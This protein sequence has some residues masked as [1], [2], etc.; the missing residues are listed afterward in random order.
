MWSLHG[1][2]EQKLVIWVTW[3]R[4]PPHPYIVKTLQKSSSPEPKGE[5]PW[6]LVCSTGALGPSKFVQIMTL[7]WL[8]PF[9]WQGQIL[10]PYAFVW[11]N[12][13]KSL[14]GRI[15]KQMTR[16]T[17]GL[18][19]FKKKYPKGLFAPAPGL[20]S[21][22]KTCKI[23]YNI[24]LQRYVFE[25]CNKWAKLQSLSVDINLFSLKGHLSLP[26]GYIHVK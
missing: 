4:W 23:M 5:W 21:C 1:S 17:K 25:T 2:G 15:L 16:V 11:E 8:W 12:I 13:R 26:C 24:R 7:G 18:C 9:L 19:W 6:A 14:N 22:I 10:L 3:P 20:Y